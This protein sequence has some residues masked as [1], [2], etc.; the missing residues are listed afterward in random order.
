[1]S[2]VDEQSS[3]SGVQQR[4]TITQQGSKVINEVGWSTAHSLLTE[5]TVQSGQYS[6]DC[7]YDHPI[8][9]ESFPLS[10]AASWSSD[11]TC[12]VTQAAMSAT[13]HYTENDTVGGTTTVMVDG[14]DVACWV[15]TRNITIT[16]EGSPGSPQ[17]SQSTSE[18]QTDAY[19]PDLG[20][21]VRTT[22]TSKSS[23]ETLTLEHL[24]PS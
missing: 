3:S 9:E 13:V 6:A 16:L 12:A 8:T 24:R 7:K 5:S 20:L 19:A 23:S 21:P 14:T 10:Q 18:T 15:I 22:V 4:I 11:A 17:Q 1:M 2:V